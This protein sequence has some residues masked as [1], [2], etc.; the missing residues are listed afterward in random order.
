MAEIK[1]DYKKMLI[2]SSMIKDKKSMPESKPVFTRNVD[3]SLH[4]PRRD[5]SI[6]RNSSSVQNHS[7]PLLNRF[8]ES[9]LSERSTNQIIFSSK[10]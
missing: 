5:F 9:S 8:G 6:T 1:E 2:S 10:C 4:V 7:N 3:E